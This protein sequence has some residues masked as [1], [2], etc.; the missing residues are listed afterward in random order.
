MPN[1]RNSLTRNL[2]TGL[3]KNV[4]LEYVWDVWDGTDL[5]VTSIL[6]YLVATK[7]F[8]SYHSHTTFIAQIFSIL[9]SILYYTT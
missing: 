6:Y 8:Y 7:V 2:L 3:V 9:F 1:S 4:I 5:Q